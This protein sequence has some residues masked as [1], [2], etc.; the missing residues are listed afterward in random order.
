MSRHGFDAKKDRNLINSIV[1]R[2]LIADSTNRSISAKAP[3][4]YLKDSNIFHAAPLQ[5]LQGHFVAL[6]ALNFMQEATDG[7]S[8]DE[9]RSLFRAFCSER[10][11]AL[12]ERIRQ[13]CGVNQVHETH[14]DYDE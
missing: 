4:D 3:S 8:D 11:K 10:E 12:I 14:D 13:F 1:N 7:L 2:T 5:V 6:G 9:V